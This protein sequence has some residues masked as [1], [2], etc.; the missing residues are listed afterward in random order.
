MV[1]F[2]PDTPT[3]GTL[4]GMCPDCHRLM[5]RKVNRT[6]LDKVTAGL[7]VAFPN[8]EQRISDTAD[9]LVNVHFETGDKAR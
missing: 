6:S 1:D 7:D 4:R 5:H 8:G 9:P 3:S 2:L